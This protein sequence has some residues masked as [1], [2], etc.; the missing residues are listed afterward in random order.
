MF[1]TQVY[2]TESLKQ[3]IALTAKRERKAEAEVIRNLLQEALQHRLRSEQAGEGLAALASL[4]ER[5]RI[6]LPPDASTNLDKYLYEY[7]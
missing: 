4:G 5:L 1:R 3:K 6:Q 7:N 2:L